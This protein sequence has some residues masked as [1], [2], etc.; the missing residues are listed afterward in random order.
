M[1]LS[2]VSKLLITAE[3]GKLHTYNDKSLD[4]I[5]EDIFISD[6]N[7]NSDS[8]VSTTSS[9]VSESEDNAECPTNAERKYLKGT[10]NL[11]KTTKIPWTDKESK[12]VKKHLS[13][14]FFLKNL[15][16]KK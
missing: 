7:S 10:E 11:K 5:N 4:E 2:K 6:E 13:K 15:P 9:L 16:G 12:A 3:K 1:M 14:H 8:D